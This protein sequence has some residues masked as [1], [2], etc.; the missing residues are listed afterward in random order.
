MELSVAILIQPL[1]HHVCVC[2]QL[3]IFS[4]LML[5]KQMTCYR[6][7]VCHR[8]R[9]TDALVRAPDLLAL[10]GKLL[11]RAPVLRGAIS[12]PSSV[13]GKHK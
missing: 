6:N 5:L 10:P 12:V 11:P 2:F 9:H 1:F 4:E 8:G 3:L 13:S 7:K